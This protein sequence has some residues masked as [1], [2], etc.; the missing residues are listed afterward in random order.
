MLTLLMLAAAHSAPPAP[1]A[2]KSG[3]TVIREIV[4]RQSGDA[5][6][7][8]KDKQERREIIV[9]RDGKETA[10]AGTPERRIRIVDV[11]PGKG[12]ERRE[13]RI[14][15]E[16]GA[17]G[18]RIAMLSCDDGAKVDSE[19]TDKDGKKT[20]VMICTKGGSSNVSRVQ[21]L[22]D[23]AKRIEG[24]TNL[25]PEAR[26]RVVTAINEAISKLPANE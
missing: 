11:A 20:R 21:Q 15:R 16:P 10:A 25:S 14:L 1:P 6:P 23:A 9:I 12:E 4:V 18:T 22:R 8:D 7:G 26:T 24:D 3:E 17:P 13:V 2:A 5:K 19:A